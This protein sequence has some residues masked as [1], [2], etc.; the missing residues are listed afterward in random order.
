[1]FLSISVSGVISTA[2]TFSVR[3]FND[4]ADVLLLPVLILGAG[5]G[6]A[7]V[8]EGVSGSVFSFGISFTTSFFIG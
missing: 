2:S 1:M 7:T 6:G 4:N 5:V 3:L 8:L